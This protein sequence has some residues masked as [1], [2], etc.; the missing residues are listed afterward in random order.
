[1]NIFTHPFPVWRDR[2]NFI[3]GIWIPDF[4][5]TESGRSEQRWEQLWSKQLSDDCFELCCIPCFAPHLALG[6][7]VQTDAEFGK[8]YAIQ[9]IIKR[10]GQVSF[11]IWFGNSTEEGISEKAVRELETLTC[12]TEWYSEHALGVSAP[13]EAIAKEVRDLLQSHEDSGH[14]EYQ[15]HFG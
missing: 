1:M 4:A 13:D 3:I 2:A 5:E 10:S 15:T 11:Q 6:D 7:H 12:L 14:L 9:R 8:E